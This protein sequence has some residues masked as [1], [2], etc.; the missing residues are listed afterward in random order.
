MT[1]PKHL[2][3]TLITLLITTLHTLAQSP[4]GDQINGTWLSEDKDGK[5]EIFRSGN[6]YYGRLLWGKY[7]LDENGKPRHDVK[8][9]D[10][11][12]R[13]S[14]LQNMIILTGLLYKDGK[15]QDGKIY[16]PIS[17]KAYSVS[18]TFRDGDLALRGYI[19]IEMLGK[20]TIWKRIA[21]K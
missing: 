17:G 6:T 8:N 1:P 9:P 20:T 13:D 3:F 10:P 18:I 4:P 21:S 19:G 15:W 2:L 5:I 12:L 14:L 16:D 7:V 11:K